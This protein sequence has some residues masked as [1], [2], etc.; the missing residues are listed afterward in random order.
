MLTLIITRCRER[1]VGSIGQF[2]A[3]GRVSPA[4]ERIKADDV[5]LALQYS[6]TCG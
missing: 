3:P 4:C 5:L 1:H 2:A 6:Y